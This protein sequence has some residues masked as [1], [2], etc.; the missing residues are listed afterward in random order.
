MISLPE[1]ASAAAGEFS[2]EAGAVL[3][4]TGG[5]LVEHIFVA[6]KGDYYRI[7]DGLRQ[8]GGW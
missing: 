7:D 1:A 3:G 8:S 4:P 5:R 6:S 2:V